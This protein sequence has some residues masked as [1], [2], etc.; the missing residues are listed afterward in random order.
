MKVNIVSLGRLG[1]KLYREF[2]KL[3]HEVKGSFCSTAKGVLGEVRYDYQNG[4]PPSELISG[5]LLVFNLTPSVIGSIELL[6]SFMSR[7]EYKRIIFV[8]ST[9]VFG[10]QGEVDED[11]TPVPE[12]NNG[13]LLLECEN[14]IQ[15]IENSVI[16]RPAGIISSDS[17]PGRYIAGSRTNIDPLKT[18]N[19]IDID[20]LVQVI[21]KSLEH[22]YEIINAVNA[23]H[24]KKGEYYI[25]YCKN[26]NLDL[27]LF[28]AEVS[29]GDKIINSKYEEFKIKSELV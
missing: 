7:V 27:P 24:P 8:S 6:K 11:T 16:I 13:K 19:L 15:K 10:M 5:D 9:S 22:D 2:S 4:P 26:N 18:V 28:D 23:H 17:H 14:F 1:I 25:T 12:K 29:G 21:I 3:G 20:D